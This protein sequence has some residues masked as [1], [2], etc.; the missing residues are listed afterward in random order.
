MNFRNG[1]VLEIHVSHRLQA[2]SYLALSP[3]QELHAAD[4][5]AFEASN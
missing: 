2:V 4:Y 5:A 1:T 3:F